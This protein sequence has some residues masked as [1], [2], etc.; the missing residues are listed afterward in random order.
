MIRLLGLRENIKI[1]KTA[2]RVKLASFTLP[3]PPLLKEWKTKEWYF[4]KFEIF[5]CSEISFTS[6]K[7][8]HDQ[9]ELDET[10]TQCKWS[11]NSNF[12][13]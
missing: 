5:H 10:N 4:G 11:Y 1:K 3:L 6:P 7:S 12:S 8:K 13:S 2:E 9:I